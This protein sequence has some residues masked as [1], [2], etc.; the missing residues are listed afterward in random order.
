M[1]Y[2]FDPYVLNVRYDTTCD[3]TGKIIRKGDE[4][5]RFPN[6]GHIFCLESNTYR[7]YL[8]RLHDMR[9]EDAMFN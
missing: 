1:R 9:F 8:S 4:A 6:T 7:D 2:T 5:V 3:E